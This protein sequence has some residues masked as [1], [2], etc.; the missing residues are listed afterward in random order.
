MGEELHKDRYEFSV[1]LVLLVSIIFT[2]INGLIA[3]ILFLVFCFSSLSA[4]HE[5]FR[6]TWVMSRAH[7]P[8]MIRS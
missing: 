5:W 1:I 7:G 3:F 8:R 4:Q 6:P 2:G